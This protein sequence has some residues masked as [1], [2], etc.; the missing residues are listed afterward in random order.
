MP[1]A[2]R[3][4]LAEKY[5]PS[6]SVRADECAQEREKYTA[7]DVKEREESRE[8]IERAYVGAR[9]ALIIAAVIFAAF[10]VA[11]CALAPFVNTVPDVRY[12]VPCIVCFALAVAAAAHLAVRLRR[13]IPARSALTRNRR[14][15]TTA[16]G[17]QARIYAEEEELI[18]SIIEDLTK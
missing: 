9:K 5:V 3:A 11:G 8:G 18:R 16:A 4:K 13:F 12:L 7:E 10:L 2:E 17:E 6:L 15:G 1:K 14:A